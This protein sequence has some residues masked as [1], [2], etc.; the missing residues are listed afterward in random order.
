MSE[1]DFSEISPKVEFI[2]FLWDFYSIND[3]RDGDSDFRFKVR[4]YELKTLIGPLSKGV[5]FYLREY[6]RTFYFVKRVKK[7][8]VWD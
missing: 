5:N 4:L 2:S 8:R 6:E 3:S 1:K 7:D